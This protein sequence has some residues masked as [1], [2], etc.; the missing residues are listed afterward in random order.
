MP[1]QEAPDD[2]VYLGID[3]GGTKCSAILMTA[4]REVLGSGIAGPANPFQGFSQSIESM[5]QATA[6]ALEDAGLG[7][8]ALAAIVAGVGLAGV[9]LP[10]VFQRMSEWAH[11]FGQ[12]FLTTDLEIACC[13]AH[14]GDDG[15][16]IISGTG[17]SGCSIVDGKTIIVGAHGFPFGDTGSGAW[18]GLEAVRAV[19][20]AIDDL[21]PETSL[22]QS[23]NDEL[24]VN[25]VSIVER[26][27]KAKPSDFA[28]L[29]NFV[30]QAAESG[31]EVATGI[32]RRG[33]G[34]L[35]NVARQLLATRPPAIAL[36]GG[37][38]DKVLPWLAEDISAQMS[39]ATNPADIGAIIYAQ[40]KHRELL[41]AA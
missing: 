39:P 16:V 20:L 33:T 13:G 35:N 5:E 2:T 3:G 18:F 34:Y 17:S 26:M 37:L 31:D 4:D 6:Y 22:T 12:M 7:E 21:G 30:F 14:D 15:A 25:G 19:L 36:L 8:D 24:D 41:A 28:R 40:R 1:H 9:N 32:I 23:L 10:M 29:A 27:M 11:P 38:K